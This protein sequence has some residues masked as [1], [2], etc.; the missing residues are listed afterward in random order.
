MNIHLMSP[1]GYTG[2]GYASLNILKELSIEHNVGL[3][4][5][6]GPKIET[7]QEAAI[8]QNSVNFAHMIDYD[9]PCIK[10]WHQF[11]LMNR[12]GNGIYSAFP[13]FEVDTM[14]QKEV[15]HLNF[16]DQI[17]VSSRWAKEVLENNNITKPI[18]IVPMGVD[19]AIFNHEQKNETNNYVF[20]TIGKWEKR[21][22]HDHIIECFNRAFEENDNVELWMVT[23]NPFLSKEEENKWLELVENSKL[24]KKIRIFPRLPS[25]LAVAELLSYA[26]CGVYISRGEGW[27]L[28]LLE[29]MAMN[30]PVIVSNYSA[31]TEYAN[32]KNSFLVDI[33]DKE[34][35]FDNKWF[36]GNS[37]WAKIGEEQLSQTIDYMRYCYQNN[38]RTNEEG[39]KTA[40]T[41]SWKNAA[42]TLV[43]CIT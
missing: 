41:L 10:M 17:I 34:E 38:I 2:Y 43:G 7:E 24:R 11:D 32:S 26:N 23:Y 30:K 36:F 25:H 3:N 35:A 5:I 37:N 40:Q 29:T 22:S 20:I 19:T 15:Y 28:E 27:N 6:G 14:N 16:P 4:I 31:H 1:I 42:H 13:F 21:K 33:S 39:L 8:V 12:V 18:K 9:S